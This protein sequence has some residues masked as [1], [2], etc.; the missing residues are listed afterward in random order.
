MSLYGHEFY[1]LGSLS[2]LAHPNH[3]AILS[4]LFPGNVVLSHANIFLVLTNFVI[5]YNLLNTMKLM[6]MGFFLVL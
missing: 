3:G 2:I 5:K 6:E 1:K 4:A